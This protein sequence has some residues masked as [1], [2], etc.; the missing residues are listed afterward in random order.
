MVPGYI[1]GHLGGDNW[2]AD[3]TIEIMEQRANWSGL[4]VNFGA[5][6]KSGHMWGGGEA[7]N[8]KRYNWDPDNWLDSMTHMPFIAKNADNQLGRL[9][10]TLRPSVSSTTR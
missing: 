4:F 9:I 3:A 8:L 7:D 1:E 6:D 2:V 5:I 10:G